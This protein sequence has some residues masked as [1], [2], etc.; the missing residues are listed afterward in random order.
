LYSNRIPLRQLHCPGARN[1]WFCLLQ[2]E[3]R[4]IVSEQLSFQ[5]PRLSNGLRH[6]HGDEL[7]FH[8]DHDDEEEEEEEDNELEETHNER[9]RNS[10]NRG[11]GF[12]VRYRER[13][14][15]SSFD[16]WVHEDPSSYERKMQ[17]NL[18]ILS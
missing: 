7:N 2:P 1:D 4:V 16:N 9:R 11:E 10:V 15:D 12:C 18:H 8:D 14:H 6:Y 17:Q 5:E 13:F 3:D